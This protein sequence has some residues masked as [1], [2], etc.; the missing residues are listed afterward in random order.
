MT[1]R[2][3]VA[4][5]NGKM[6]VKAKA[7]DIEL[8]YLNRYSL[9]H[10]EDESLLG[11]DT[12]NVVYK[13]K[14]Y[15]VGARASSS[16]KNEGKAS[17]AHIVQALVAISRLVNPENRDKLVV[18]YGESVDMYFDE[19]HKKNIR[20]ALEGKHSITVGGVEYVLDIDH[21]QILPE[22][23]GE[24]LN[25]FEN[26]QGIQYIVDIGGGTINFLTTLDGAPLNELSGSFLLGV[27]N[28]VANAK[29]ELKRAGFGTCDHARV[30][31]YLNDRATSKSKKLNDIL[32]ETVEN[33]FLKLDD[34][35]AGLDINIH[36]ILKSQE[37]IFVGGGSELF[38]SQI[39]K[40]YKCEVSSEKLVVEDALMANVRGFYEYGVQMFGEEEG[41][42]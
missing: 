9:G 2:K 30:L 22:G 35:L 36:N 17:E 13:N 28:V 39:E 24:I 33:Q 7:E 23:I 38:S 1:K 26:K 19:E 16:D 11:E 12:F 14:R 3:I 15:V 29:R 34:E 21:V 8:H 32:D 6:N 37:V 27:N 10:V 40:F 41:E 42:E 4:I 5:D 25:D 20:I 31:Q 18:I